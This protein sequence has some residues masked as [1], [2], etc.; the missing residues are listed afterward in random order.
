MKLRTGEESDDSLNA[1]T[2]RLGESPDPTQPV[3]DEN[4]VDMRDSQ[5]S[6]G[7]HGKAVMY[8]NGVEAKAKKKA[9]EI[10]DKLRPL[11]RDSCLSFCIL[12]FIRLI[13]FNDVCLKVLSSE[14]SK[15]FWVCNFW[16]HA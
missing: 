7:W 12:N 9:K 1:P 3:Y 8:W 10:D 16:P 6:S 4:G 5:V 11:A 14:P 13:P 15:H 2:L